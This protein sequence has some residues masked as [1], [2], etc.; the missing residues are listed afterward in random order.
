MERSQSTLIQ[1]PGLISFGQGARPPT[2]SGDRGRSLPR[3]PRP[4][5]PAMPTAPERRNRDRGAPP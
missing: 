2:G 4:G 1:P 3:S 5:A